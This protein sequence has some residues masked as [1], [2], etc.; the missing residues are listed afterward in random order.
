[1]GDRATPDLTPRSN[2]ISRAE[3]PFLSTETVGERHQRGERHTELIVQVLAKTPNSVPTPLA[4]APGTAPTPPL[5]PA[6]TLPVQVVNLGGQWARL[7]NAIAVAAP[8]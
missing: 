2:G 7:A 6:Q 1:M 4:S 5:P 3:S 8:S